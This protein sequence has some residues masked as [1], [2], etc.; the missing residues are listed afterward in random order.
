MVLP[1]ACSSASSGLRATLTVIVAVTSGWRVTADRVEAEVLDRMVENHLAAVEGEAAGGGGVGDVAGGDRAVEGA[2][3]GGGANHREG[4]AV[5]LLRDRFGFLLRFEVADLE[6]GAV[7]LEALE[8]RFGGAQRLA[9]GQ[10]EVAGVAVLDGDDL[11]HLA[12]LGD[13]LEEYDLHG[14]LLT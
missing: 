13:A 8:V 7:G 11:A 1:E 4:L 3:V 10:E 12:E 6:L 14:V 9:L 2:A 5:E